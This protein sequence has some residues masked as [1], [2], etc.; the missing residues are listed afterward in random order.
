M[1]EPKVQYGLTII[2]K[3]E[4]QEIGAAEAGA[5]EPME[6]KQDNL[7]EEQRLEKKALD[8]LISGKST[9]N[10][11]VIPVQERRC[12]ETE[13]NQAAASATWHRRKGGGCCRR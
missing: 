1:E 13:R 2:K 5:P 12:C 4:S 8:A 3:D 6:M 9:D 7:T 11:L 10:D